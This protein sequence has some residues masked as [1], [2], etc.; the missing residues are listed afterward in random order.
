MGSTRL[1]PSPHHPP[2]PIIPGS[3][4]STQSFSLA[5]T[6]MP[7]EGVQLGQGHI[8]GQLVRP[9]PLQRLPGG[10]SSPLLPHATWQ[11]VETGQKLAAQ[12]SG[13]SWSPS[14]TTHLHNWGSDKVTR[15]EACFPRYQ[16]THQSPELDEMKS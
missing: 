9:L 5:M 3:H 11:R 15:G 12:T 8:A 7:R 4:S 10:L 6:L 1:L 2:L 14:I 16:E 13:P